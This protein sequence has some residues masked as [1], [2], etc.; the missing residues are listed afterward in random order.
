MV[1]YIPILELLELHDALGDFFQKARLVLGQRGLELD[2]VGDVVAA[3]EAMLRVR[4]LD[5]LHH[6]MKLLHEPG[7]R[8]RM[9]LAALEFRLE[10]AAS[11]EHEAKGAEHRGA[12]GRDGLRR[13]E[14]VALRA[15]DARDA[16]G[17]KDD[18]LRFAPLI[19]CGL[20]YTQ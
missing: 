17:D 11:V 10:L 8:K 6:Q 13:F 5:M 2:V 16:E 20:Q 4:E 1:V 18:Y 9:E 15:L 7:G 14:G 12:Y 19:S 3:E